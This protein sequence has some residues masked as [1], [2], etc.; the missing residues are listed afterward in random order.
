M[1]RT[2]GIPGNAYA[3]GVTDAAFLDTREASVTWINGPDLQDAES[4]SFQLDLILNAAT[5]AALSQPDQ[6]L[7]SNA[8]SIGAII[9]QCERLRKT[10]FHDIRGRILGK[11]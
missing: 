8:A 2:K 3:G 4:A 7:E 9:L 11:T 10:V 1:Y 6:W 5:T